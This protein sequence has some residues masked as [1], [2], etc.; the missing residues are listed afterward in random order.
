MAA[1]FAIGC[2]LAGLV[3][4]T[5]T[6][7]EVRELS[8]A[9]EQALTNELTGLPNRRALLAAGTAALADASLDR[10]VSLLLLDLDRFK[11]A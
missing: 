4:L 2:V 8:G 3:R 1:V 9:R 5:L 7:R 10:L 6:F 11:D